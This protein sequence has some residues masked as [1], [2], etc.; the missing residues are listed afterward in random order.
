MLSLKTKIQTFSKKYNVDTYE[1]NRMVESYDKESHTNIDCILSLI[2]RFREYQHRKYLADKQRYSPSE[3]LLYQYKDCWINMTRDRDN[4]FWIVFLNLPRNLHSVYDKKVNSGR[5]NRC[6]HR[7][8][9]NDFGWCYNEYQD[10]VDDGYMTL[11][12]D[13]VYYDHDQVIND[14]KK[15][16]DAVLCVVE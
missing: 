12:L 10:Y 3:P 9:M 2:G 4:L 6:I 14:A 1:V 8:H 13:E 5:L 15:V 7:N 16:I 11:N